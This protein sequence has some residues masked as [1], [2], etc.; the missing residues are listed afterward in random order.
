M[1]KTIRNILSNCLAAEVNLHVE[2]SRLV[3]SI[4]SKETYIAKPQRKF[5]TYLNT[6][7]R[8]VAVLL[9]GAILSSV[10][11]WKIKAT[12]ET[13]VSEFYIQTG[14]GEKSLVRLPDGSKIWMNA[15]SHITYNTAF[16]QTNRD[17][18]LDGEAYFEVAPNAKVPFIVNT[19][20]VNVK[21]LGTKFNVTSYNEDNQTHTILYTGKV[22]VQPIRT[23]QQVIL[24][25]NQMAIYYK[26]N[27]RIEASPYVKSVAPQ[28][29]GR[30]LTFDMVDLQNIAKYLER[31]YDVTFNFHNEKLRKMRFRGTVSNHESLQDVLNILKINTNSSFTIKSDTVHVR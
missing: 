25:D 26:D 14:K 27:E 16:G 15:C 9:I 20:S 2:W 24:T 5:N 18:K 4:H 23:K 11:G 13:P 29:L 10:V 8:Y 7:S 31:K 28:W 6:F 1:K 21:A 19:N 3:E 30:E 22:S 12:E 17:V